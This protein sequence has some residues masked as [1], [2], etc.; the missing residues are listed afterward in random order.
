[1]V[2]IFDRQV[3]PIL[4]IKSPANW[5]FGS[6]EVQNRFSSCWPWRPSW[7]YRSTVKLCL[8]CK[9]PQ[10][11]LISFKSMGLSVLE[12]KRKIDFRDGGHSGDLGFSNGAILLLLIYMSS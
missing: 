8:I 6:G 1:M 11:F 10:Y 2:A 3:A 7:I 4:P 9:L 12:K 5:A